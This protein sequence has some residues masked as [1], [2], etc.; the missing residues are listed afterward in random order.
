MVGKIAGVSGVAV[1]AWEK[2]QSKPDLEIIPAIA[3]YLG[4]SPLWLAWGIETRPLKEVAGDH[5]R[6]VPV[7]GTANADEKP[8]KKEPEN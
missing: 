3:E 6:A 4:V 7:V 5:P 8:A 2:G 1:G